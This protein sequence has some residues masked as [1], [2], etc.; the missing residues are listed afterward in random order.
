MEDVCLFASG[1]LAGVVRST[2]LGKA[3]IANRDLS[4]SASLQYVFMIVAK[5]DARLF[6]QLDGRW[7]S[8]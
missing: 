2:S 5:A 8:V 3:K 6:W 1:P 4:F 7:R